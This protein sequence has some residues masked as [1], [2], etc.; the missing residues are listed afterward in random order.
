MKNKPA[1][2]RLP[3]LTQLC[4][5]IPAHL[6]PKLARRHGIDKQVRTFTTWS[7]VVSL[8]FAQLTHA[9]GLNDA[10]DTFRIHDRWLGSLRGAVAPTR[11][12]LS[13]ANKTRDSA[14][15]ER[16][17]S[18]QIDIYRI[19]L[20]NGTV[21]IESKPSSPLDVR[22]GLLVNGTN[23]EY[24]RESPRRCRRSRE[25]TSFACQSSIS[26]ALPS[27]PP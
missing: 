20:V 13:H 17:Q 23:P 15:S 2:V 24:P 18:Y 21:K 1:K 14:K 8:I 26:T 25:S 10:C 19:T 7:H 22:K 9:V 12:T 27:M 6:D 11:N 3:V 4:K 16:G 5:L